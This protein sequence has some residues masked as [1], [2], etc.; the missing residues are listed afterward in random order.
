MTAHAAFSFVH[1]LVQA[2]Y[3]CTFSQIVMQ[4]VVLHL[5]FVHHA[6][7]SFAERAKFQQF[8]LWNQYEELIS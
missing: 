8:L 5:H 3:G 6:L 1:N 7:D 2:S 4:Q